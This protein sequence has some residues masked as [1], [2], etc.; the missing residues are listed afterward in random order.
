MWKQ[1]N[2]DA[3]AW[4]ASCEADFQGRL[5]ALADRL[6]ESECLK[7][8]RLSG[9][10]CSG[11]TTLANLLKRRFAERGKHLHLISIDDFYY[12]KD[13]LHARAKN[14]DTGEVDYDSVKTIDLEALEQFTKEIF[15]KDVADC[16]IFDFKEGRRTGVRPIK[17]REKDVFLFEGIQVLYPEVSAL[18]H[19]YGDSEG[20]YISPQSELRVGDTV[21]ESNEI[22]LLRRL[23]RDAHFRRTSATQTFFLWDGVRQNEEA[24]IF[25]YVRDCAHQID[26]TMPYELGILKPFLLEILAS[27]DASGPYRRSADEILKKLEIV[28]PLSATLIPED[29]LYREFV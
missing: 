17:S 3:K 22:R 4:I 2:A 25:P 5:F 20:V 29:S 23:V 1:C 18:L 15:E 16:P 26:S 14:S 19:R 13:F 9:P 12:D 8:I 11:K 27:V 10:T 7:I 24:H 6:L 21:W 28:E